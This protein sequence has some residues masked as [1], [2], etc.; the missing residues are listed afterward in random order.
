VS[1]HSIDIDQHLFVP[2][3]QL[4]ADAARLLGL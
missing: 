1:L 2:A 4:G 3:N